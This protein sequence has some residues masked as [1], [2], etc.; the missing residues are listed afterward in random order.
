MSI[1]I[2]PRRIRYKAI[3]TK[4]TSSAKSI[5]ITRVCGNTTALLPKSLPKPPYGVAFILA[6]RV[7]YRPTAAG[8]AED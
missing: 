3:H 7:R 4:L 8:R 6:L 2:Q 1:T 5:G